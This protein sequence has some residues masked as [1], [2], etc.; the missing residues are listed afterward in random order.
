LVEVFPG[1]M[2]TSTGIV[3]DPGAWVLG[4]DGTQIEG[5]WAAGNDGTSILAG[6]YPEPGITMGPVVPFWAYTIKCSHSALW[7]RG[8]VAGSWSAPFLDRKNMWKR[9]NRKRIEQT[10][11]KR[12]QML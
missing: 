7:G 12:L 4:K 11:R 3:T 9:V 2:G 5:L 6:S 10:I 8:I 1:D